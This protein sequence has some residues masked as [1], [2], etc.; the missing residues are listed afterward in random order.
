MPVKI[1]VVVL[2]VV[3]LGVACGGDGDDEAQ[4]GPTT[5]SAPKQDAGAFIKE[6]TE[7][8]LLGQYGRNWETLHPAHQAVVSRDKY[9][10]CE[11]Q[12]DEGTG[13]TKIDIAVVETYEEPVLV[14]GSGTVDSTAVTLRFSY[15]NPLTGKRAE[16]HAT[17]HAISVG[18]VL[19]SALTQRN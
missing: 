10:S 18:G 14:R 17:A 11:R 9:D 13:A 7:R 5:V 15:D 2:L 6:I 8:T 3:A 4:P 19:D 1:L 12:S 16:E